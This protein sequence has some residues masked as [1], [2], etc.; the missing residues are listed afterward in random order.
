MVIAKMSPEEL[1]AVA[2][3][4]KGKIDVTEIKDVFH[5]EADRL[6]TAGQ[7][8]EGELSSFR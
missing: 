6:V 5:G 2:G 4:L 1:S 3:K 7:V 8:K